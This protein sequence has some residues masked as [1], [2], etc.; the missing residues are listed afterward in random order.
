MS[1]RF[2]LVVAAA[3][4]GLT[5]GVYPRKVL[6]SRGDSAWAASPDRK[7]GRQRALAASGVGFHAFIPKCEAADCRRK[8]LGVWSSADGA[9]WDLDVSQP[10]LPSGVDEFV[11]VDTAA[12]GDRT[13]VTTSYLPTRGDDWAS[14]ALLSPLWSTAAAGDP[15]AP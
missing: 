6:Y 15:G 2:G 5:V 4:D 10:M 7:V 3:E 8:T 13:V 1:S 14:V 11:D 9:D 12:F